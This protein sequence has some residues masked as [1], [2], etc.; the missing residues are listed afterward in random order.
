MAGMNALF[1]GLGAALLVNTASAAPSPDRYS[2]VNSYT[3]KD[4]FNGWEFWDQPDPTNGFVDYVNQQTAM[5]SRLAGLFYNNA[6]DEHTAFLGVDTTTMN[7]TAGRASVRISSSQAWSGGGLFI[8]D[9]RHSPQGSCGSWP[10][11]W[12]VGPDWPNQGEIDIIEG[13]NDNAYNSLTLHT[14]PNCK[15]N[16][17]QNKFLGKQVTT[18]C[19]ISGEN[20]VGCSIRSNASTSY[21]PKAKQMITHPAAGPG[22]NAA[23]GGVYATSWD[24][25]GISIWMFPHSAVPADLVAGKPDPSSWTATPLARFGG[26]GCDYSTTFRNQQLVVD[27]TFCGDWAGKDEVW[28]Q[29]P[30]CKAKAPTCQEFVANNPSA[31]KDTYWEIASI[32]V[33]QTAS[34]M[35]ESGTKPIVESSGKDVKFPATLG[36]I[37]PRH[38][39]E[40]HDADCA[41]MTG[42]APNATTP[43]SPSGTA[44]AASSTASIN[45]N[46]TDY[47]NSTNFTAL[48]ENLRSGRLA[49]LHR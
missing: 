19:E 34:Q 20:N 25:T 11:L 31:F 35:A 7:P 43:L 15:S 10:A 30:A 22:F 8:A 9:V 29:S 13:V 24:A 2:L 40:H 21:N 5:D 28:S 6:T 48:H 39:G 49:R 41:N 16:L 26:D 1:A 23:G 37:L 45:A 12:L 38:A 46:A 33:Y 4:F 18:D 44:P 36:E 3:G 32:Q 17:P 14:G 27:T 42:T 47:G